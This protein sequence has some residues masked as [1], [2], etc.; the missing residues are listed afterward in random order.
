MMDW[1]IVRT[2]SSRVTIPETLISGELIYWSV[3]CKCRPMPSSG[4][5]S[6][7]LGRRGSVMW[8]FWVGR[9]MVDLT[10]WVSTGCRWSRSLPT[11]SAG[12][13]AQV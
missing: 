6:A 5:R 4:W 10:G 13:F 12:F 3:S 2:L 8:R 9:T 11:S 7:S 1:S